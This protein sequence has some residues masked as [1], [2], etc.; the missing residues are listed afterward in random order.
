[1]G[2][3]LSPE[4][5]NLTV[6]TASAGVALRF[7]NLGVL[8]LRTAWLRLPRGLAWGTYSIASGLVGLL[9]LVL[10]ERKAHGPLYGGGME[11]LVVAP[12]HLWAVLL[13]AAV[14]WKDGFLS[15]E[16][17]PKDPALG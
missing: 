16:A 14:L 1:M 3:G 10:F 13:G 2:V 8:A 4:Y 15:P 17:V 5:V 9:A 7:A 6:H 11:R 12:V